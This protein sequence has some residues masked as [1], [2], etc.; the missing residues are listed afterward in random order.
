MAAAGQPDTGH[1]PRL[2]IDS[3]DATR[4]GSPR[5]SESSPEGS[6]PNRTP[7]ANPQGRLSDS[8]PGP[9]KG[10]SGKT[11]ASAGRCELRSPETNLT[12]C[13]LPQMRLQPHL[14][15]CRL[16]VS[17]VR[18]RNGCG[19]ELGAADHAWTAALRDGAWSSGRE[20]EPRRGTKPMGGSASCSSETTGMEYGPD[21]GARPRSRR[22]PRL[23]S[24]SGNG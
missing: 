16:A 10:V 13:G 21:G 15:A 2:R 9:S 4:C 8:S 14:V 17:A 5:Q 19:T 1:E 20:E 3:G 11:K 6:R 12:R 18:G 7:Q 24:P 23:L 22:P